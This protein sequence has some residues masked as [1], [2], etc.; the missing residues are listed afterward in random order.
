MY[1]FSSICIPLDSAEKA[2]AAW[3]SGWRLMHEDAWGQWF[4]SMTL[5][6]HSLPA[7]HSPVC[8]A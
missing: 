6:R 7:P 8:Q 5:T 2:Y 4:L 3:R 1:L